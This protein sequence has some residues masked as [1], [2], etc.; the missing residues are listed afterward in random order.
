MKGST[1]QLP[2]PSLGSMNE[3]EVEPPTSGRV[4]LHTTYGPLEV[5]LWCKEC[6]LH[7]R[8]FLQL[9]L[10]GRYDQVPF[11]R[12]LAGLLEGGPF[13]A[14]KL[15]FHPRLRWSRRGLLGVMDGPFFLTLEEIPEL[16]KKATLFG[17]VVGDTVYN[18]V[19]MS[20]LEV[21]AEG[22]FTHP[23]VI[24]R[25]EILLNPFE[26]IIP[27]EII[28][29]KQQTSN[30]TATR[31]KPNATAVKNR[32]VLSFEDDNV[33]EDATLAIPTK[34]KSVHEVL[35]DPTLAKESVRV[36]ANKTAT[37]KKEISDASELNSPLEE[38]EQLRSENVSTIKGQIAKVQ[39]EL[40]KMNEPVIPVELDK[41]VPISAARS[42]S[43]ASLLGVKRTL[44]TNA[45]TSSSIL[46]EQRAAYK[47]R[48][49]IVIGKRR[50][51]DEMDTLLALNNFREKLKQVPGRDV[52][53]LAEV[54]PAAKL[55]I[56]KLHGLVGCESCRDTFGGPKEE[57]NEEGWLMHRLVF[58]KD[59]GYREIRADLDQLQVIDPRDRIKPNK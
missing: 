13:E 47:S 30:P 59:A 40:R 28:R 3:N 9:C 44:P 35:N 20:E 32:K 16:Y 14:C 34:I 52:T 1:K 53:Q 31:L 38:L 57:G 37:L 19:R 49:K 55:D 48:R 15:E 29:K 50:A 36:E 46:Q 58:D 45:D 18:M 21:D 43:L 33:E 41:K 2:F 10:E 26:D 6:P 4:L 5:E 42:D 7:T 22:I 27:R 51:G 8:T 17:K 56:C 54:A 12:K 39:E 23:P 11:S 25:T 24:T